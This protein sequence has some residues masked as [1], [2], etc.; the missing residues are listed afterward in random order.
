MFT[1]TCFWIVSSVSLVCTSTT[2][3]V[4][5]NTLEGFVGKMFAAKNS[6][7]CKTKGTGRTETQLTFLYEDP[8]KDCGVKR[9]GKQIM[10]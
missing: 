9:Y 6:R 2:M 10:S 5:L 4:T 1:L 7:E 8:E 3:T